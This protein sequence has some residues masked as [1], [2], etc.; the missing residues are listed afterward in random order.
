MIDNQA[1]T[2]TLL[3][4]AL[5]AIWQAGRITLGYFQR[6]IEEERKADNTKEINEAIDDISKLIEGSKKKIKSD[7]ES[8]TRIL[9]AA[10]V[11]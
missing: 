10:F 11:F 1:D 7:E 9:G 6:P 2:S 8:A 5:D 3:E 4:F